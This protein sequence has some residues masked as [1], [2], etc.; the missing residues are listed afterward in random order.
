MADKKPRAKKEVSKARAAA[1]EAV[2]N[3]KSDQEKTVAVQ[4]LRLLRFKEVGS[5]RADKA[6]ESLKNLVKVCDRTSYAWTQ[7]QSDKLLKAL[8]LQM[9]K[10]REGLTSKEA[11]RI[12]REKFIL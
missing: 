10:I 5:V 2:K 12:Q 11:I 7:E 8:D 6:I 4:Q 3:A 9:T 1:L